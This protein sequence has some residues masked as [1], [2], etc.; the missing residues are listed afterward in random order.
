MGDSRIGKR[1]D[2]CDPRQMRCRVTLTRKNSART[3]CLVGASWSGFETADT[4]MPPGLRTVNDLLRAKAAHRFKV[5]GVGRRNDH[6]Q[7]SVPTHL[8]GI[9]ADIPSGTVNEHQGIIPGPRALFCV[10]R[11]RLSFSGEQTRLLRSNTA[12]A[13]RTRPCQSQKPDGTRS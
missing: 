10:S 3:P 2:G 11:C 7:S 9:D 4:R 8:Y 1:Q 6:P 13:P 12:E 5:T